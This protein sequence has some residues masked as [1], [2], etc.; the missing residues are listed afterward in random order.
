MTA[1]SDNNSFIQNI[2]SLLRASNEVTRRARTRAIGNLPQRGLGS[3]DCSVSR[4][5]L[6]CSV[7]DA[8]VVDMECVEKLGLIT[9][10]SSHIPEPCAA[11][12]RASA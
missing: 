4:E 12:D 8:V 10:Q 6:V 2:W 11:R 1:G 9:V 5:E 7:L 3:L